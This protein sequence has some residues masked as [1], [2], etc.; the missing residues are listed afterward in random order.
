M[1]KPVLQLFAGNLLSKILGLVREVLVA[2]LFG[3]GEVVGSY[4]VAQTGTLVP[5]NFL[6]SDSLNSAFIPQYKKFMSLSQD[7]AQTL[8]WSIVIIF[9]FLS[10]LITS[11]LWYFSDSWVTLL[12]P[13]FDRE[14]VDL[15]AEMIKVMGFGVVFYL[16]SALLMFLGM[17]NGDFVP[18][19]VRPSIQNTGLIAGAIL[20]FF[21]KNAVFLAWGF[22]LS[23]VI[24]GVWVVVREWKAGLLTFPDKWTWLRLREV[25]FPFWLTLRP[26][27]FLPVLLQ[28]NIAVERAVA[29]LIGLAAVSSIDYAKFLSETI[30]VLVSMPVAFVGLGQWSELTHSEMGEKLKLLFIPVLLISIPTSSFLAINASIV[31]ESVYSR[32]AFDMLSM[33]VTASILLG[34]SIGLWAQVLGY[35]LIKALNAQRRNGAV[36]RIMAVA[37]LANAACNLVLYPHLGAMTLGLG[38]AVYGLVLLGGTLT[39]LGLWRDVLER[40]WILAVAAIG[41]LLLSY[42]LPRPESVWRELSMAIAVAMIYWTLWVVLVPH[43]RKA[44]VDVVAPKLRKTA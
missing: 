34:I 41:Y 33:N 11:G 40:G 21:L 30:I 31:V 4:R 32:G 36:L 29:S 10:I 16:L 42:V 8:F 7:K 14:T 20:A 23:Y 6:T 9:I 43:I 18:M 27:L 22:T 13:G 38:N 25:L 1:R 26:L 5:I 39:A 12:A 19:A 17:A 28:G 44:V 15:A 35:V 2:A 37:L 24:F 3:T